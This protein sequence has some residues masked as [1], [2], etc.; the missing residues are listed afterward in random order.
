MTESSTPLAA[1]AAGIFAAAVFPF[2][3][4]M[5][6]FRWSL[7]AMLLGLHLVMKAPVWHLISRIDLVGGSTGWH[8][9]LLIDKFIQNFGEWWLLGTDS[10]RDW[11]YHLF[12][13][14][15]Q[16]VAEGIGGG[17]LNLALFVAVLSVAFQ[18][19][20]RLWRLAEANDQ[21]LWHAWG[22]GCALFVHI[23]AFWAVSYFG[24][25][26]VV[27][28]LP[29]AAVVSLYQAEAQQADQAETATA[30][31]RWPCLPTG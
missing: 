30:R 1:A 18:N 11:G 12:D 7:A 6:H 9:Y 29:L 13:V 15:N 21:P 17:L 28:Y 24:Q 4:Y 27:W 23:S 20:G 2:R 22:L 8:R 5:R 3:Q 31:W 10:T 16:Y 26:S 19:A 14:T 25:I